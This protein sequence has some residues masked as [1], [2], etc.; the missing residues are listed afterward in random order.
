M[1]NAAKLKEWESEYNWLTCALKRK[2]FG[3]F[4]SSYLRSSSKLVLNLNGKWGTGKTHFL[5]RMYVDLAQH[6][7]PVIYIDAWESD[8]SSNPLS[9]IA[10]ELVQQLSIIDGLNKEQRG[11]IERLSSNLGTALKYSQ[12]L[13]TAYSLMTG[14]VPDP[15]V[16]TLAKASK[17]ASESASSLSTETIDIS[18]EKLLEKIKDSHFSQINAMRDIKS[19]LVFIAELLQVLDELNLP[20]VVLVD[21][22][23]RCRP[24]YAVE[25]LEVIKHFFETEHF[26]FVCASDTNQLEE[27][28]KTIYGANFSSGVYLRR[29]FDRT[30]NLPLPDIKSYIK[31]KNLNYLCSTQN[32]T[33][34]PFKSNL[35]LVQDF[36]SIYFE[37]INQNVKNN[38]ELR[39]IDQVLGKLEALVA[40][41]ENSHQANTSNL[42]A[43]VTAITCEH[44]TKDLQS[45]TKLN[46]HIDRAGSLYGF[47][48]KD[49]I[50]VQESLVKETASTK[51]RKGS[52][53]TVHPHPIICLGYQVAGGSNLIRDGYDITVKNIADEE[54]ALYISKEIQ[55]LLF[56]DIIKLVKLSGTIS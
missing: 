25:F 1:S 33:L 3:E 48:L 6:S 31:T 49:Y 15:A 52:G 11:A 2:Q 56:D 4:I 22:L 46:S 19:Q 40:Y 39:D 9:V 12:P 18:S 42:V 37:A 34:F 55:Y 20:V 44:L 41:L 30:I 38:F 50:S 54:V 36:L 53:H 24:S 27:S 47:P 7:H 16:V 51:T 17:E 45:G 21:E 43:I 28:I 14:E 26:V 29:F 8:F 35:T 5:K 10:S 32:T 23:D 13:I